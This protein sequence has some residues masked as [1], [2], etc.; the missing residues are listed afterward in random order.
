MTI[1]RSQT[2]ANMVLEH[3]ETARIFQKNRID[4]CCR[5]DRTLDQACEE[6]KV[7]S[8]PIYAALEAT[9][10]ERQGQHRA[11]DTTEMSVAQVVARVID[12]HHSYLR[13]Q[14]P[15]LAPLVA[16]VA[17]VHGEHLP[18][19][20]EILAAFEELKLALE[21]H[22]DDEEE[23]LFPALMSRAPDRDVI[24]KELATMHEDHL[25][26]GALLERIRSL[27]DDFRVPEWGCNSFRTLFSELEALEGDLLRHIHIE[28]H[29]LMARFV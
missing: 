17:R 26:V 20:R 10:R 14:L 8:E 9:I 24:A 2:I 22:L 29:V 27:A 13:T 12:K 18:E 15:F 3:P 23:V 16:K 28:N 6:K 4:F 11:I 21:P 5:G 7:A 19:L 1:D 25:A